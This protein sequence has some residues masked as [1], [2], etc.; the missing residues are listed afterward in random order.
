LKAGGG[1]GADQQVKMGGSSAKNTD[2]QRLQKRKIEK[3][4]DPSERKDLK[5]ENKQQI[6]SLFSHKQRAKR[7]GGE[8]S[9]GI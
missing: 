5:N 6:S 7:V 8:C 4:K 9:E 3:I 2:V 1:G